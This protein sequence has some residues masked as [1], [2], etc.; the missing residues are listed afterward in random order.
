MPFRED[1]RT[2]SKCI[3]NEKVRRKSVTRTENVV[4]YCIWATTTAIQAKNIGNVISQAHQTYMYVACSQYM[5]VI[6]I[7]KN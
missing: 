2:V 4:G 5:L 1:S 3:N 6:L 7:W